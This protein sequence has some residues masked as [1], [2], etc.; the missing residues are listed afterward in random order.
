V[1][2]ILAVLAMGWYVMQGSNNPAISSPQKTTPSVTITPVMTAKATPSA[3]AVA[4]SSADQKTITNSIG[5]EFVQIQAGEFDMGSPSNEKDRYDTE[6][7]VH[8][9]K[10]SNAF[11]MGTFEVTQKQWRD[12]MG[13]S[14]SNFKGDDL[15][16][17]QVS[18]NDAQE[19]I[20]KLNEKQSGNKYRLP[21]EDFVTTFHFTSLSLT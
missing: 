14:P 1:I 8:R 2:I 6:G 11:Y 9:V 16:V 12:V 3:A 18:W 7:P 21:S 15:P 17:E 13:T 10:I 20:K 19:F 5:M 4:T